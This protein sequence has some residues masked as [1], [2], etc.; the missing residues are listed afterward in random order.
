M[1]Y[2]VGA[3][4]GDPGLITVRALQLVEQA[5]VILHDRLIIGDLLACARPDA[6]VIDVGKVS[7]DGKRTQAEINTL[8]VDHARRGQTVVRLKGGDPFVFGRGWEEWRACRDAGVP[9]IVVPGVSSALA[10]PAAAGIP[11]TDRG[12]G[13]TF[14]VVTAQGRNGE[15]VFTPNC[16]ALV[17]IDTVV[18]LM[19]RSNLSEVARALVAAGRDPATPAAC[20]EQGTTTR[21]R[22]VVATLGTIAEA[23]GREA[24][25]AP[26]VTVVGHVARYADEYREYLRSVALPPIHSGGMREGIL[27]RAGDHNTPLVGKRILITRSAPSIQE[28]ADRLAALGATPIKAPLIRADL[29][30]EPDALDGAIRDLARYDWIA[31]TSVH[32]VRGFFERLRVLGRDARA[33]AP[34]RVAAIG[35]ITASA[36]HKRGIDPE[37]VPRPYSAAT[38]AGD[39]L[40]EIGR[41]PSRVL[42]PRG[43]LARPE[44]PQGLRRAGVAVDEVIAYQI[45]ALTP[46]EPVLR[47]IRDGVDAVLLCSPSAAERFAE[48]RLDA[49]GAVIAC[50]GPSTASAAR[51]AG[52]RIDVVPEEYTDAALVA[53]LSR[54]FR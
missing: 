2:L 45:V 52:M 21:Q 25:R 3:G 36:L 37:L 11:V 22:S 43:N 7:G 38:L 9:C 44:L 24:L 5:D 51:E 1:V 8:L 26:V 47:A 34:C 33:L 54:Y 48:L 10:V 6:E 53:A 39:M 13:R 14:A 29:T 50:I 28:L 40:T 30:P 18:V 31:F 12:V 41:R 20:I 46:P 23:A 17:K 4:P 32:A 42:C 16:E 27:A 15:D 19:G 35:P 49:A